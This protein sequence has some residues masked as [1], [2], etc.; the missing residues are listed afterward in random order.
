MLIKNEVAKS[1]LHRAMGLKPN[2]H[3]KVGPDQLNL[4]ELDNPVVNPP[5]NNWSINQPSVTHAKGMNGDEDVGLRNI[6]IDGVNGFD[7][8]QL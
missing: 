5:F 7:L 2:Q 3:F 1:E 4:I 6:I 8:V